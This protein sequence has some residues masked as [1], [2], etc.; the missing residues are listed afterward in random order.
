MLAVPLFFGALYFIFVWLSRLFGGAD[1]GLRDLSAAYVFTLVPIAIAYH[2]AHYLTYLLVQGQAIFALISDPLGFG[3]N[4]FGTANYEPE[5]SV[6]GAVFVWYSPVVLIVAG[7]VVAVYLAHL[8][9]LRCFGSPKRALRSQYPVLVLMTF[10]TVFS[11][12]ILSQPII[13]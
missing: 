6:V 8:V 7:H 4:L 10:Y 9:S 1:P 5:P 12:W 13:E 2:T 3:W 11:L